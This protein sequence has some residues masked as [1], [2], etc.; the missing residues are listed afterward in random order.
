VRAILD[1]DLA[2]DREALDHQIDCVRR[3]LGK[4]FQEDPERPLWDSVLEAAD[5]DDRGAFAKSVLALGA[6][7]EE[8]GHLSGAREFYR[9]A[10]EASMAVGADHEA[11]EAARFA[12]RAWRRSSDWDRSLAWYGVAR[13][14]AAAAG[15]HAREAMVL[16]GSAKVHKERGNLPRARQLL[17]EALK[18]ALESGDAYAIGATYHDIGAVAGMAGS[19]E[20]AVRMTWLAVRHYESEQDR[21][22]ALTSLAAILV[23]AQQLEAAE[24]AY[25]VVARRAESAAYRLYALS[26]FA[27]VA[28]LRKK[29]AE[30]ERRLALLEDAGLASGSAA[31]RAGDLV[32]RGHVYCGFGDAPEARRCFLNALSLAEA[33]KLGQFVIQAEEGL[34]L[35]A[36]RSET[37]S[38]TAELPAISSHTGIEE[39]R[40]ELQLMRELSP[41]LAGV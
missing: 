11:L 17:D 31:L 18:L 30:Y 13:S 27:R 36:Q 21:L 28:G 15:D 33:H 29:R 16:D 35:L 23:E 20:E 41:E 24:T 25:S 9:S 37:A 8:L 5:T 2:T 22:N 3:E 26:G 32:D 40:E 38:H 7:V 6:Q 34:R 39:I 12:G 14:L 19:Y 10:Y 1:D 4:Q